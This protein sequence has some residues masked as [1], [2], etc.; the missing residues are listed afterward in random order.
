MTGVIY[1]RNSNLM[2]TSFRSGVYVW[3]E[4]DFQSLVTLLPTYENIISLEF[5]FFQIVIENKI[6]GLICGRFFGS[7]RDEI[8]LS[9]C[10]WII[11]DY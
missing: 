6:K 4:F 11:F 8:G 5:F 10:G 9:E 1:Y 7:L 3:E 2:Y